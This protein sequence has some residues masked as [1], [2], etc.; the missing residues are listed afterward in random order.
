MNKRVEVHYS[1]RV[2]GVGFRFTAED[3]ANA[4]GIKGYVKNLADGRVELVAEGEE[5]ILKEFLDSLK[6]DMDNVIDNYALNWFEPTGE[7]KRFEIR[8]I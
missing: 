5:S 8:S 4:R 7:F 1:G 6:F 2:Q 3:L